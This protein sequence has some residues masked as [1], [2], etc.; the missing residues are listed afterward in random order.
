[1]DILS[2][3]A[4]FQFLLIAWKAEHDNVTAFRRSAGSPAGGVTQ[5]HAFQQFLLL[6]QK[7]FYQMPASPQGFLPCVSLCSIFVVPCG[8]EYFHR[9]YKF[10]RQIGLHVVV[11]PVIHIVLYLSIHHFHPDLQ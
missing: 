3:L 8:D 9:I 7:R 10:G 4:S 11:G 1:M 5:L 6:F 2:S